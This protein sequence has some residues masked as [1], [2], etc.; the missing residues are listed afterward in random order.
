MAPNSLTTTETLSFDASDGLDWGSKLD[1]AGAD[2][3]TGYVVSHCHV[4][5]VATITTASCNGS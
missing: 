3:T 5:T 2:E 4:N 1:G